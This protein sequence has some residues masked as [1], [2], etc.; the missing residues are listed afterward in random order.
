MFRNKL[1][2]D[3]G[4]LTTLWNDFHTAGLK[5]ITKVK[6]KM[7]N[8]LV[9]LQEK[10]PVMEAV[11]DILTSVFDWQHIRHIK[12][13]NACAHILASLVAYQLYAQKPAVDINDTY[14]F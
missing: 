11:F 6:K 7:K 9:E 1:F 12:L 14:H 10:K 2:D 8:K 13:Q 3:K 5:I 4:Y